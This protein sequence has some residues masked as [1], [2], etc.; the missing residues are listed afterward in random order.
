MSRRI[1]SRIAIL[2]LLAV[3]LLIVV[4]RQPGE[5]VY[6]DMPLSYWLVRLDN[7]SD[8]NARAAIRKIGTNA[9]PFL[10]QTLRREDWPARRHVVS[11]LNR[12]TWLQ[13]KLHLGPSAEINRCRALDAL[14]CLETAA[15]PAL[16]DILP[17]LT[18]QNFA[19]KIRAFF[20]LASIHPAAD[21]AKPVVPILMR[22]LQD[23]EWTMR[24]AAL[25]GLIA[26][27]PPPPEAVPAFLQLLDDANENVRQGAMRSLVAQTNAMVI[28]VLAKQLHDKDSY[29][30]TQAAAQIG[31]FGA[32][33]AAT[34]P[35]LRELLD[36]PILTVRQ[37]A[38]NALAAITGQ[39]LSQSAPTEEANITY[40]FQGIP[41]QQFLDEYESMAGKK[42]TLAI[43]GQ[44]KILRMQTVRPL[45]KSEAMT[46]C[47]EVLREQAGLIIVHGKD[48]S[49]TAIAKP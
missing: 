7:R 16:P 5:F 49:L 42:V 40:N 3:V 31:T 19:V 6:Q 43:P 11:W 33:A 45:T 26:L 4:G 1:I 32:A 36:S 44:G 10:E 18:N 2:A 41:L 39:L 15:Q 13:S 30:V 20:A 17:L 23:Q 48:G 47:E 8:T 38:T 35:R 24:L 37:A 22:A 25:N 12:H 34:A 21:L 28:P 9:L 27:R 14:T 29:V 46:L